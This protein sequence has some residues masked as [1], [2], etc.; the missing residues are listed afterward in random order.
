VFTLDYG[1]V[2]EIIGAKKEYLSFGA[3]KMTTRDNSIEYRPEIDGLRAL[4]VVPV[5]LYHAHLGASGGFV[6]VDVFF[7]IS[8]FLITSLLLKKSKDSPLNLLE[9]WERRI[10]RLF[11]GLA[12]M[13]LAT[14]VVG[15]FLL[16]PADYKELGE[17]VC[18]QTLLSSNIFFWRHTGYFDSGADLKPLLHTW[19]LAVEEQFYLLYPLMLVGLARLRRPA[20]ELIFLFV[21]IASFAVSFRGVAND[22]QATFYLL[23]SRIWELG[24][25][26]IV[27]AL[28]RTIPY[29]AWVR[30][31][32]SG[33]GLVMIM[34]ATCFYDASTPFPGIAA[35]LPCCG[36]ALF[37]QSNGRQLTLAGKVLSYRP[38]VFVGLISYS[39]YLWHWPVLVFENY[40][41]LIPVPFPVRIGLLCL[42]FLLAVASW[43]YVEMPCRNRRFLPGKITVFLS[44]LG[45]ASILLMLGIGISRFDGVDSRLPDAVLR[46]A[47]GS[48]DFNPNFFSQISLL[49]AQAGRFLGLGSKRPEDPI[50]LLVWGDS[51]A[52]AAL[53]ALDYL[54]QKHSVR[55]FAA[56]HAATPPLLDYI[57]NTFY[58]FHQDAPAFGQAVIKFIRAHQIRN[59]ILI[60]RWHGYQAG[61]SAE[62]HTDLNKTLTELQK[63][64]AKTW[65]MQEVPNFP[66]DVPRALARAAL[67]NNDPEKL[68]LPLNSYLEQNADQEREFL[69]VAKSNVIVLNPAKY[70]SKGA[71]VP[72]SENGFPICRDDH[73]LTIHGTILI[74]PMFLPLFAPYQE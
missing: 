41:A 22:R 13:T 20:G 49:D 69:G 30:E 64:G 17:S 47:N 54:C 66:W 65:I 11:P 48:S 46:F 33:I 2:P 44:A 21:C 37:I 7:V 43:K 26:A 28:P 19:S 55:A 45:T 70:F 61:E 56:T 9:F 15:W 42:C 27:A 71:I 25:G 60:A 58:S 39:L 6:G 34:Y 12:V 74:R 51:H 23:P 50:Q 73:H 4:A 67:F 62:F 72:S 24:L 18:A 59:V 14:L 8:G 40:W 10:R 3:L 53:P 35:L 57:P 63:C 52:M 1:L 5:L 29:P 68:N 32:A 16:L 36:A 38:I 31:L